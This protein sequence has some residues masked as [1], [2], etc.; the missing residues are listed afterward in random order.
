MFHLPIFQFHGYRP[1]EDGQLNT[2]QALGFEN[3]L[4]LAFHT[5]EGTV[6]DLESIATIELGLGF[7]VGDS[8]GALLAEHSFYFLRC[9]RR[10]RAVDAAAHKVAHAGSLAE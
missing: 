3:F 2:Y 4:D 7:H 9:H 6:S 1:A 10:R 5:S 8:R